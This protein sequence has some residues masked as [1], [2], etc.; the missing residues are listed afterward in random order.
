MEITEFT[1][2]ANKYSERF[3]KLLLDFDTDE[4]DKLADSGFVMMTRVYGKEV[5]FIMS[6]YFRPVLR[7]MEKK[8]SE[9]SEM[10]SNICFH[11]FGY[12]VSSMNDGV[13][14]KTK[15]PQVRELLHLYT[16]IPS[17]LLYVMEVYFI[18]M[19]LYKVML[20]YH[21]LNKVLEDSQA[22]AA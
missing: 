9:N 13:T 17:D 16:D 15:E 8:I 2:F 3:K 7:V 12:T 1:K 4:I 14:H 10:F 6:E 20:M 11:A 21:H 18:K 22:V 5:D 19:D